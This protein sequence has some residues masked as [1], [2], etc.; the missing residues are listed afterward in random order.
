MEYLPKRFNPLASNEPSYPAM[1][2]P[3]N[4]VTR[5]VPDEA[6]PTT[7]QTQLAPK[8]LWLLGLVSNKN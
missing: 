1:G 5:A 2:I 6:A 8:R 7:P 4:D 3:T